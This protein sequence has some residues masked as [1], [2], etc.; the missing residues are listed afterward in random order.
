MRKFTRLVLLIVLLAVAAPALAADANLTVR[1][2]NEIIFSGAVA[3]P[4]GITSVDDSENTSHEL[5]ENSVL[6]ALLSADLASENFE[7]SEMTYFSSFGSLYLKCLTAGSELCDDWQYVVDGTSP[8]VGID[9]E[10]LSGGENVYLYFGPTSQITLSSNTV[11][12]AETLTVTTQKYDY[13]NNAWI[14]R[15][16]VV[17]GLTQPNSDDPFSPLEILTL[18]VDTSGQA[19]FSSIPVGTY[20][21]GVKEDFYFPTKQ[22]TVTEPTAPES[23]GGSSGGGS[24]RNKS[25]GSVLGAETK[26]K[27][28]L[29]KAFEFLLSQQKETGS[30]GAPIYTDW[31]AMALATGN[32]QEN[33][34]KLVKY[35]GTSLLEEPRLTDYE[36]RAMAL[37]ALGLNPYDTNGVNYIAKII[38][39]F[40]G[41]QFG[42]VEEDNDDIFALIALRNA[43]YGPEEEMIKKSTEFVLKRQKEN[44]SWDESIDM[45]GAAIVALSQMKD[46]E[47]VANALEKA[48]NFLRETQSKRLD[49]SWGK[50]ASSTAWV[51][52]GLKALGEDLGDWTRSEDTPLDFLSSV[53][54][55][56]GGIKGESMENRIWETAY[57]IS[58]LSEKTWPE[59]MRKFEK[60]EISKPKVSSKTSL[61]QSSNTSQNTSQDENSETPEER[62]WFMRFLGNIFGF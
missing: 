6:A 49:G 34:I 33:V 30:W 39:G 2:G 10:I 53:Q 1:N 17:A 23:S 4:T 16:G 55:D 58:A 7:V 38:A 48:K 59:T 27:F 19:L 51:L 43:G 13:E 41:A 15:E 35:L 31:V 21:V 60:K 29:P 8:S 40:D 57:V 14:V 11:T 5:D 46:R 50:S 42:D 32:Y 44:G 45:T 61:L 26:I 54:E 36:R 18:P 28:N 3:L 62:N 37:M 22:L 24:S 9:Q 52:E 56:D 47:Q 12:T 25:S 20:D